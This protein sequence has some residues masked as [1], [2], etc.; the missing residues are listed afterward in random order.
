ML[1]FMYD[2]D[3]RLK[4]HGVAMSASDDPHDRHMCYNL[5]MTEICVYCRNWVSNAI[6][7]LC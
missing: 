2:L 7:P 5:N 3:L 6:D 1:L 4:G